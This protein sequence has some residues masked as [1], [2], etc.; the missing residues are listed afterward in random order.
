MLAAFASVANDPLQTSGG[1]WPTSVKADSVVTP[2][3]HRRCDM[4]VGS[5]H[6]ND[7]CAYRLV[8]ADE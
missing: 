3:R 5:S 7:A 1:G 8:D 4:T 2:I 6:E